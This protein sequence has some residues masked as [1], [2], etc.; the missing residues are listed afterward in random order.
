MVPHAFLNLKPISWAQTLHTARG[1]RFRLNAR[2]DTEGA[3]FLISGVGDAGGMRTDLTFVRGPRDWNIPE[4]P[5]GSSGYLGYFP[6]D[7]QVEFAFIGGGCSVREDIYDD[8]WHRI[9]DSNYDSC[10]IILEVAPLEYDGED[11]LWDREKSSFLYIQQV[12]FGFMR[13]EKAKVAAP[14]PKRGLFR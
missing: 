7:K 13:R 2:A 1:L 6:A 4:G 12:E 8:A 14:P 9:R 11:P 5:P 10:S 3:S